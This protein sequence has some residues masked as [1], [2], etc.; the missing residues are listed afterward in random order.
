MASPPSSIQ[1]G[2][3][4]VLFP[5]L[6]RGVLNSRSPGSRAVFARPPDHG[7]I[8]Y[9]RA[10]RKTNLIGLAGLDRSTI[11]QLVLAPHQRGRSC[12]PNKIGQIVVKTP[13]RALPHTSREHRE[14]R[15]FPCRP[16]SIHGERQRQTPAVLSTSIAQ[17]GESNTL[18]DSQ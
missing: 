11:I 17:P 8:R 16:W 1:G 3:V 4:G 15:A 2:R 13:R 9:S 18:D 12:T 7:L 14:Y 5:F 10:I 6:S